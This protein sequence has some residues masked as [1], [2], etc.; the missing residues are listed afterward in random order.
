M[1]RYGSD[2]VLFHPPCG[3]SSH[4]EHFRSEATGFTGFCL[5][6]IVLFFCIVFFTWLAKCL[7]FVQFNSVYSN[8]T[9]PAIGN[10]GIVLVKIKKIGII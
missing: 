6:N 2:E 9:T 3:A 4:Q 10:F 7:R 1:A 5:S 8:P